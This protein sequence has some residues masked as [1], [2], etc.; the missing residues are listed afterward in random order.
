MPRRNNLPGIENIF[1]LEKELSGTHF[2]L[3]NRVLEKVV[4]VF[5]EEKLLFSC[6]CQAFSF[7][8]SASGRCIMTDFFQIQR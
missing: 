5:V 4:K 7:E 3:V 2:L 8:L 6:T 1:L